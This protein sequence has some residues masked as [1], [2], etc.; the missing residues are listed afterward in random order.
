MQEIRRLSAARRDRRVLVIGDGG[1]AL[2]ATHSVPSG[3]QPGRA[4]QLTGSASSDNVVA[5]NA[6]DDDKPA[7]SY[8]RFRSSDYRTFESSW[9]A[10]RLEK[11]DRVA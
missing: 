7:V 5:V 8:S 11:G 4:K 10:R 1:I 3:P 6:N 9:L 2:H